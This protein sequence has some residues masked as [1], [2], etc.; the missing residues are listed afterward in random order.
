MNK[1]IP[2]VLAGLVFGPLGGCEEQGPT[3]K[4]GENADE[5]VEEM[6]DEVD[7]ATDVR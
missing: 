5:A 1:L 2:V 4:A 6:K 3:E 7:D